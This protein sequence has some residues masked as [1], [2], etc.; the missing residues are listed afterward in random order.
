MAG[1]DVGFQDRDLVFEVVGDGSKSSVVDGN[2]LGVLGRFEK[3]IRIRFLGIRFGEE[4]L[5]PYDM[6]R[7]RFFVSAK[8]MHGSW[9]SQETRR[10]EIESYIW[11]PGGTTAGR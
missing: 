11:S 6:V 4:G 3:L 10:S 7:S 8:G 1:G 2:R 9:K 5:V